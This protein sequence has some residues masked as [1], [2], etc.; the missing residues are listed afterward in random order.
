[1]GEVVFPNCSCK[2]L[3]ERPR[4]GENLRAAPRA[5][6]HKYRAGVRNSFDVEEYHPD[7]RDGWGEAYEKFLELLGSRF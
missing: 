1:M 7:N 4:R 5:L 3:V 2:P 6:P